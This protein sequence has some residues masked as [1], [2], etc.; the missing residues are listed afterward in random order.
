V[1]PGRTPEIINCNQ[2]PTGIRAIVGT[3]GMDD[4]FHNPCAIIA[5]LRNNPVAGAFFLESYEDHKQILS[6]RSFHSDHECAGLRAA[7]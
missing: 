4:L 1:D 5:I 7:G 2:Y 6:P 3:G